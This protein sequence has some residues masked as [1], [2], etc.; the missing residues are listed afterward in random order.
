M[1][2]RTQG[3][4][5]NH[6]TTDTKVSGSKKMIWFI[7]MLFSQCNYFDETILLLANNNIFSTNKIHHYASE[8][9]LKYINCVVIPVI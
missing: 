2:Y 6:Y 4:H 8:L 3:E 9:V 5:A 1:I 7:L